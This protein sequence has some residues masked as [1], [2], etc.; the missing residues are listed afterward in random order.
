MPA[1]PGLYEELKKTHFW[2]KGLPRGFLSGNGG[3]DELCPIAKNK[4]GGKR[5]SEKDPKPNSALHRMLKQ[6]GERREK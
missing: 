2:K 4:G 1:I 6:K 5:K 3:E